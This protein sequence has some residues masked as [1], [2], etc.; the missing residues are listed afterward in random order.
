MIQNEV[1]YDKIYPQIITLLM[2][3]MFFLTVHLCI[4]L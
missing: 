4:I 1:G 3:F 2:T